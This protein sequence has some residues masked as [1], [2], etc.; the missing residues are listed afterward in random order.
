MLKPARLFF[1]LVI[2][3]SLLGLFFVFEASTVESFRLFGHPYHFVKT[4]AMWL[5][6]ATVAFIS[7]RLVRLEWL[8]KWALP[9][10]VLSLLFLL[11]T[12]IPPF[13]LKLNG[14]SR[15]LLMPWGGTLQPVELFKLVMINF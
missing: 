5:V 4:Q 3:L 8:E 15:W 10:Y 7:M 14:A 12:L 13:G 6:L 2:L 9:L 1:L 11:L